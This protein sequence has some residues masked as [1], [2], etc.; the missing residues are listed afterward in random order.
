MASKAPKKIKKKPSLEELRA[1]TAR[2]IEVLSQHY[3]E[4]HCALEYETPAQ[5]LFATI[6]SAQCTD[7]MVNKVTRELFPRFPDPRNLAKA[8]LKEVEELVRRTGFY[9]NKAKNLIA[10]AQK[11]VAEH[12][13]E[14]PKEMEALVVLPGVGRKTA[15]VVRGNAFGIPGMVV[16]T[17][18]KR[19]TNLLGLTKADDPVKIEAELVKLVP[20]A[21]WT[22]FSHWIIHH[23]RAICVARRPKCGECPVLRDC[24][25]GQKEGLPER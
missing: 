18:V 24:D 15:N 11:L 2:V 21:D 5:L 10:C 17:H 14:V 6:L 22:M 19:I 23:G 3:P 4:A 13:G 16:D 8:E 12:G 1:K 7:V 20:E 25:F 9:K